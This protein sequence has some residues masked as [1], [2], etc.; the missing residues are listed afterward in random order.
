MSLLGFLTSMNEGTTYRSLDDPKAATLE[1]S[2][3][4]MDGGFPITP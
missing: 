4:H 3:H 2:S 1:K